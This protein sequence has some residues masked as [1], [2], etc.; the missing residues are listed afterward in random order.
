MVSPWPPMWSGGGHPCVYSAGGHLARQPLGAGRPWKMSA[1]LL[2]GHLEESS[3][4]G[5]ELVLDLTLEG[6]VPLGKDWW[7]AALAGLW[8]TGHSVCTCLQLRVPRT[9]GGAAGIH[10]FQSVKT[11]HGTSHLRS[12]FNPAGR[13]QEPGHLKLFIS[14]NCGHSLLLASPASL[15]SAPQQGP[16]A[17]ALSVGVE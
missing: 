14:A 10:M 5:P 13:I 17:G 12:R 15:S 16:G 7:G 1:S 8:G 9:C 11:D 4:F 6:E 2:L 3:C